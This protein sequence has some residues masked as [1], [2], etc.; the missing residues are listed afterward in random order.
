MQP[1]T[2]RVLKNYSTL[3]PYKKDQR[4]VKRHSEITEL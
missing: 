3:N 2:Q 4:C 1:I